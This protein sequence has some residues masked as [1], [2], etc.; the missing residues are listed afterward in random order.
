LKN[1]NDRIIKK[2]IF[3]DTHVDQF[4]PIGN[5]MK[6]GYGSISREQIHWYE[7]MIQFHPFV[8]SFVLL[9][10][11]IPEYHVDSSTLIQGVCLEKPS[12][13]PYDSGFFQVLTKHHHTEIVFAGHDHYNDYLIEKEGIKLAYG[14]VSGHYDYGP[15]DF[16]KG[17][18]MITIQSDGSFDTNIFLYQDIKDTI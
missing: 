12:T 2:L 8:Q 3:M 17:I 4:Y 18:R 11:P 15:K 16:P 9:H 14:R 6:W 1:Q 13:P 5:E 10:I 7:H